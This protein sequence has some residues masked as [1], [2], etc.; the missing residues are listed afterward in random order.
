M[1][2]RPAPH[3]HNRGSAK[4][5]SRQMISSVERMNARA[6]R[7][8]ANAEND[9]TTARPFNESV[10]RPLRPGRHALRFR[11]QAVRDHKVVILLDPLC[12]D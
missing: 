1:R 2:V 3:E 11:R 4:A 9:D 5:N 6:L 12:L 8:H 7:R 10:V